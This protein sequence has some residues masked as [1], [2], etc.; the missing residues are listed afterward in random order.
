MSQLEEL[1]TLTVLYET[2][3]FQFSKD[4]ASSLITGWYR[5]HPKL[6]ENSPTLELKIRDSNQTRK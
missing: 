3:I 1:E 5:A 2:E 4:T 6:P